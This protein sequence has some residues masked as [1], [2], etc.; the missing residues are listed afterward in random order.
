[1]QL[2]WVAPS[3]LRYQS[4]GAGSSPAPAHAQ[5]MKHDYPTGLETFV[6]SSFI[7]AT[8]MLPSGLKQPGAGWSATQVAASYAM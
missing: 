4:S 5:I 6:M 2:E 7:D 8:S 1:M 3:L